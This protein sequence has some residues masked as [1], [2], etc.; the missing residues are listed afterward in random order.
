MY[1]TNILRMKKLLLIA[2][3]IITVSAISTATQG[4]P[5]VKFIDGIAF[6]SAGIN[7]SFAGTESEIHYRP[8]DK[9]S[10][11][12]LLMAANLATEAC[13]KLQF[14]YAQLIDTQIEAVHN[15]SLFEFIEDW[16]NSSYRYGGTSKKGIDCSGLTGLLIGSVYSVA[17]PRTAKEQ[18]AASKKISRDELR[19]GDLVFFNT[20]GGVSHV[21]VYLANDFFVHASVAS[22]VTISSLNDAYYSRKYIGAGRVHQVSAIN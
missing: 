6:S 9:K 7:H 16:W 20:R 2:V 19:E 10:S 13:K 14:K 17:I 3:C 8:A 15:F 18:Y 22:G 21:G 1:K 5:S 12:P 11:F 4:Q